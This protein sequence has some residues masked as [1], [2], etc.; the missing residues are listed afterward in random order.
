VTGV[1]SGLPIIDPPPVPAT[2]TNTPSPYISITIHNGGPETICWV[3]ISDSND[4]S[5]GSN[6]LPG[7]I[8]PGES[9]TWYNYVPDVY[10]VKIEDCV[11]STLKTWF[12][13]SMYVNSHLYYP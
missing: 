3:Y 4:P 9:Y 7:V 1:T 11:P 5:W 10:D 6:E 2:K 12:G 13:I 8:G